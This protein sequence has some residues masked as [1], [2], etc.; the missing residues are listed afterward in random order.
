MPG[1]AGRRAA[2]A[3][4]LFVATCGTSTAPTSPTST[5]SPPASPRPAV[6]PSSGLGWVEDFTLSGDLNGTMTVVA[7]N[8]AGQQSECSGKNSRTGGTWASTIYVLLGNQKY[9]VA[10][11]STEYRGPASYA[12]DVASVQVFNPDHSKAWQNLASDPV[13][14]TVNA[15]EESGTVEATLTNLSNGQ[16][17]LM[18]KGTWSCRT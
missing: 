15:D 18:L 1:P 8:A 16:S 14:F 17:K 13:K 4:V 7:P 5:P 3:A 2:V 9:G 11:L 10:F 6:S 12:E